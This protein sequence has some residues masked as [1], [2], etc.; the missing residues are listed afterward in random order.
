[1]LKP[2]ARISRTLAELLPGLNQIGGYIRVSS[3]GGPVSSFVL[4]GTSSLDFLAAV[5]PQFIDR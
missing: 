3:S 4:Y 1:M 5:P 2:G